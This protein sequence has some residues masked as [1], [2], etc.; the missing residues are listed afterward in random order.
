MGPRKVSRVDWSSRLAEVAEANNHQTK[1]LVRGESDAFAQG[2]HDVSQLLAGGRGGAGCMASREN[3][4]VACFQFEH[5]GAGNA[6]LRARRRPRFF[7]KSTICSTRGSGN[8]SGTPT[9]PMKRGRFP[10]KR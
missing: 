9:V 6:R 1:P 2:Q 8:L 7:R 4:E 10:S 5:N 3:P